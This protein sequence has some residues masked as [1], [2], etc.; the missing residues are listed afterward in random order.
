M[1]LNVILKT[2]TGRKEEEEKKI[3]NPM[4]KSC[5]WIFLQWKSRYKHSQYKNSDKSESSS[6]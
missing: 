3:L 4:F 5:V 2:T 6:Y 1:D